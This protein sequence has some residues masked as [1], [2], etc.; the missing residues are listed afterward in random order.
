M[1]AEGG[2]RLNAKLIMLLDTEIRLTGDEVAKASATIVA[3]TRLL[4]MQEARYAELLRHL[5]EMKRRFRDL[6]P[7]GDMPGEAWRRA[8]VVNRVM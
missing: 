5:D 6:V 7:V 8:G 1:Y 2:H 4:R 3:T